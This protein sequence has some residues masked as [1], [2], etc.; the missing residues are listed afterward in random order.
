VFQAT[1]L[2][3]ARKAATIRRAE[4]LPAWLHGVAVRLAVRARR[5][6]VQHREQE[7]KGPAPQSPSP[8]DEL[9]AREFLAVLDE[10]LQALPARW[11]APLILCCLEGLSNEE[12]A[13]RLGCS[14]GAVKGRL[15]RGRARL[16]GRLAQR[17]LTLPA[18]LA[19]PL[20]FAPSAG[21]VPLALVQSALTAAATGRGASPAALALTQGVLC[22]ASIAKLRM[23][24]ALAVL[25]VLAGAGV[26]MLMRS[27]EAGAENQASAP[28]ATKDDPSEPAARPRRG[29]DLHG[30]PLPDGAVLRLGTIQRRA[31][32]AQL[33]L[34]P[35]GN[36]LIGVRGGKYI[37]VWDPATGKLRQTRA[38]PVQPWELFCLSVDGRLVATVGPYIPY[39]SYLVWDVATGKQVRKLS[40]KGSR[41]LMPLAF[42]ADG[43]LVAMIGPI[44]VERGDPRYDIRVWE[45]ASGKEVFAQEVRSRGGVAQLLF[46]PDSRRLLASCSSDDEGVS[47][48]DLAT[49]R[50]VWQNKQFWAE[51]VVLTP[52][53]KMVANWQVVGHVPVL[54]LA[55]GQPVKL[56]KDPPL[57]W[58][59]HLAITPNGRTL[60]IGK[61]G[62]V[63][64]WDLIEG[65]QRWKLTGAGEEIVACPDNRTIITNNG[66]LQ[67]W[68]L[69]TG[70][71]LYADNFEQGHVDDISA[72]VFSADGKRLASASLDGSVRLW[73]AATGQPLQVWRGHEARR[74][75]PNW[76]WHRASVTVLDMTGDGRWVISADTERIRLWDVSRGKET[77]TIPLPAREGG[78]GERHVDHLRISPDGARAVAVFRPGDLA[79]PPAVGAPPHPPRTRKLAMWDVKTGT[80]LRQH[81]VKLGDDYTALTPDGLTFVS[82]GVLTDVASGKERGRLEGADELARWQRLAFSGDGAL[83]AGSITKEGSDHELD[84][85]GIWETASG[86]RIARL[87]T[88]SWSPH[89]V[90]HPNHRFLIT[91]NLADIQLWDVLTGRL[92]VRRPL[93][94]KVR[95][96]ILTMG[97]FA[98]GVAFTPDGRRLATGHP[99][100]TILLWDLPLPPSRPQPLAAKELERLWTDLV[101]ND[102]AQAWR[103]VW[104]LAEVPTEALPLLRAR[105]TMASPALR[106][107]LRRLIAALDHDSFQQRE[108]AMKQLK[109]LGPGA[110][111]ALR[112]ALQGKPAAEQRRRIETLL[113][114][115]E[116][117]RALTAEDF[118]SV[119]AVAVLERIGSLEAQRILKDLASGAASALLS[120]TARGALE[121]MR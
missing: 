6:R 2:I 112:A 117:P 70:Q 11:R 114:A 37:H 97:S 87:K 45:L 120:R 28:G 96:S 59:N 3:L 66:A 47:C 74:P 104:R 19:G 57:A 43:K 36:S 13:R 25:L 68:D 88:G 76:H 20:L 48:W 21:A 15:E 23:V 73:D 102:A 95:S 31:V 77:R 55:T 29:V 67:R 4:A 75:L 115:L 72:I 32:G 94:E 116:E 69:A 17:G 109:E 93:H 99:D 106:E 38:L 92:V 14:P 118:R 30:D 39:A 22:M 103:A 52:D 78:E 113:A 41:S 110:E 107:R 121:R 53:G 27:A 79:P 35:D 65:K 105:L 33:A 100:G 84:S 5:Y 83:I 42:S 89:P 80:L 12:A 40:I 81:R 91:N 51:T 111:S 44:G 82:H 90:F 24:G 56:A 86:K 64:V 7:T 46:T 108:A 1:F 10:E 9:T 16:R 26:G 71:P 119:R 54:D 18:V 61:A 63:I 58:D 34:S 50:R 49:G 8:L 101:S 98:S 60:L 62:A 85:L